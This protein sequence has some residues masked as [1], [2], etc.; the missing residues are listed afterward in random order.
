MSGRGRQQPGS[1][2]V[3]PQAV[4]AEKARLARRFKSLRKHQRA[5][6]LAIEDNFPN[7]FTQASWQQAFESD[8]PRNANRTMVVTGDFSALL[9]NYV[10][11]LRSAAGNRLLGLLPHRRPRAEDVFA[12]I[13]ADHGLTPQQR[14]LLDDLYPLEGRLERMSPDVSAREVFDGIEQLRA[15]LP[16]LV[17]AARDWLA[18]HEIELK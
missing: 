9:N 11:I 18:S 8:E 2:G 16:D 1:G 15:N 10:E 6:E 4:R 12:A 7:D 5:L 13:E 17:K 14:D 3:A